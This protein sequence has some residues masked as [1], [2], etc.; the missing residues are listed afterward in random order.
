M[1]LYYD[2]FSDLPVDWPMILV[3][4]RGFA[5]KK[6]SAGQVIACAIEQI[7]KGTSEQDEVAALLANTD[8]LAWQTIDRYLEQLAGEMD[9]ELSLRKWR[10]AELEHLIPTLEPSSALANVDD[11]EDEECYDVFFALVVFWVSYNDDL[12]IDAEMMPNFGETIEQMLSKQ[13]AWA[14]REEAALRGEIGAR[15]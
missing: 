14:E 8:L 7:G 10:L 9:R 2:E 4:W 6:L 15:P 12:P 1:P 13:Q 5:G 3:G 11:D